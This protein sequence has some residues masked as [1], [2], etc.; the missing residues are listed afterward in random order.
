MV[1][2][3]V[4]LL[5][6]QSISQEKI[7]C[8]RQSQDCFIS[9]LIFADD[10][11]V[12]AKDTY[13]TLRNLP[14]LFDIIKSNSGLLINNEKSKLYIANPKPSI[15][16]WCNTFNIALG[17][18]PTEY[19]GLPLLN[20]RLNKALYQPLLDSIQKRIDSWSSKFLPYAGQVQQIKSVL[21]S[22]TIYW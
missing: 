15:I 16:A 10:H 5:L 21:Q 18:L 2:E 11:L 8:I 1:V 13:K 3:A 4:S 6:E 9:H 14:L 19:L 20:R 17:N 12:L 7:K 22:M